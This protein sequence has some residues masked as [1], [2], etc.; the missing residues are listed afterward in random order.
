VADGVENDVRDMLVDDR[1]LDLA[2]DAARRD[3]AVGAKHPQVLG[4]KRL[5]D[6]ECIDEFVHF[7]T[8]V[9]QLP[10]DSQ[11]HRRGERLE[12]FAGRLQARRR[13][14][15]GSLGRSR[16]MQRLTYDNFGAGDVSLR[17]RLRRRRSVLVPVTV[18]G[19]VPVTVV[20]IVDV[21]FVRDRHVAAAF[22]VPV[23]V[24]GVLI[25]SGAD[26]LVRVVPVSAVHVAVVR[27]VDVVLVRDGDV[28]ATLAVDVRMIGVR[29]V[30]GGG[31]HRRRP[32]PGAAAP[33]VSH[34][35]TT[36]LHIT[37]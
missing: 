29:A 26:A 11:A 34:G 13:L 23:L 25:V 24:R 12:E 5:A 21:A 9:G 33:A 28:A 20:D 7:L 37:I 1:V 35:G 2:R 36:Y 15:A 10:H 31:R 14:T 18:V 4:D 22:A 16:H 30:L 8:A 17:I 32:L 3:D 19:G 6:A 27:V